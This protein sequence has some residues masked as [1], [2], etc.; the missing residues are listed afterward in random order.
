MP[1]MPDMPG[2]EAAEQADKG[3][4][5]EQGT[6]EHRRAELEAEASK[7]QEDK[8]AD[9]TLPED[10]GEE[11]LLDEGFELTE[12]EELELLKSLN[13][14]LSQAQQRLLKTERSQRHVVK[15]EIQELDRRIS[16]A[17][18]APAAVAAKTQ[19][20]TRRASNKGRDMLGLD[21]FGLEAEQVGPSSSGTFSAEAAEA[22]AVAMK[23]GAMRGK[24][25]DKIFKMYD[26]DQSGELSLKEFVFLMR[27]QDPDLTEG[28]VEASMASCG[29][30][31][32]DPLTRAKFYEWI[33]MVFGTLDDEE[34]IET[35]EVMT[36]TD[37]NGVLT[38]ARKAWADRIF[39]MYDNNG[40]GTIDIDEFVKL[41]QCV[42]PDV[43]R[44]EVEATLLAAGVTDGEMDQVNFYQWINEV[45]GTFDDEDFERSMHSMTRAK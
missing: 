38:P 34:F 44:A 2:K 32:G 13:E 14:E 6:E 20:K 31:R 9:A 23:L 24:W 35:M 3:G 36:E 8:V 22:G 30:K 5:E 39:T 12:E 37:E 25:A 11:A 7:R 43:T 42:A 45:F 16:A 1:D 27:S 10:V 19:M 21:D 40:N 17:H 15:K 33:D 29:L 41:M 4:E 18:K 28:E 26:S